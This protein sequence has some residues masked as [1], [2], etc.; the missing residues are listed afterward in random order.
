VKVRLKFAL[1]LLAL[2]FSKGWITFVNVSLF[3][4]E[5]GGL[6]VHEVYDVVLKSDYDRKMYLIAAQHNNTIAG[7]QSAL[8]LDE[9]R[10]HVRLSFLL[11][12]IEIRPQPLRAAHVLS[13]WY[14]R[15]VLSYKIPANN[16]LL[17]VEKVKPRTYNFTFNASLF[18]LPHVPFSIT[19]HFP[20]HA[21]LRDVDPLP[22]VLR[23][24][25]KVVE[26]VVWQDLPFN[27]FQLSYTVE[28]PISYE[29]LQF[30]KA[31]ESAFYTFMST[32]EGKVYASLF[33]LYVVFAVWFKAEVS[34]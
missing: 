8:K 3:A 26:C 13:Q 34:R 2:V 14:G 20:E 32:V 24:R 21:V 25:G 11:Q 23:K 29:V 30:F 5:Q 33:L 18:I 6:E 15:I 19:F 12:N 17:V 27:D 10:P 7:W 4:D 16:S 9:F 28:Q 1:L 22:T 31:Q